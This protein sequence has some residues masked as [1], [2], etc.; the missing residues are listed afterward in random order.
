LE[1]LKLTN[2]SRNVETIVAREMV[3][4][5]DENLMYIVL[6]NLLNNAWKYSSKKDRAVIEVGKITEDGVSTFFIKDNGTG[7]DSSK[8]HKLFL[9]FERLHSS[10]DFQGIGIGLATVK[11]IIERHGGSIRAESVE[12]QGATFFWRV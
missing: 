7:F 10:I 5:A 1:G 12:G 9:P 4:N 8:S 11:R 2:P 3:C 6:E